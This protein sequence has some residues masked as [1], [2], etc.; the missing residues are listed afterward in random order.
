MINS[1]FMLC[2]DGVKPGLFSDTVFTSKETAQ[3]SLDLVQPGIVQQLCIV[4]FRFRGFIGCTFEN[5]HSQE[6][7]FLPD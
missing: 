5:C 6:L 3:R 2:V 7:E 4:E 1:I